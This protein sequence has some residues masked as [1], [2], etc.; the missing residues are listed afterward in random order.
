MIIYENIYV[1]GYMSCMRLAAQGGI[2]PITTITTD[3]DK[4]AYVYCSH[5]SVNTIT[6]TNYKLYSNSMP[7]KVTQDVDLLVQQFQLCNNMQMMSF[8][9][10]TRLFRQIYPANNLNFY[11]HIGGDYK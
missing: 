7:P 4:S 9:L 6:A 2:R 11:L 5:T 10:S 3:L 1:L 8:H